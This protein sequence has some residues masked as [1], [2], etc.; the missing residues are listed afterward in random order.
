M[1]L[2]RGVLVETKDQI[3]QKELRDSK[4]LTETEFLEIYKS[5]NY[6]RPYLTADIA[7]FDKDNRVLLIR[8]KGHPFITK[9][10]LP[11]GFANPDENIAQTASRELEEETGVRGIEVKALSLYSEP[12]RDPRGWVVSQLFCAKINDN[13]EVLAGDDAAEACWFKIICESDKIFL[14]NGDLK[15]SIS[16]LAFDHE[17]ML[18]EVLEFMSK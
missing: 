12:G 1:I 14:E 11:G 5:K 8:R 10:A 6:M 15:L 13:V 18:R 3:E 9:F 16:D 2:K 17:Q 7:V 4:G